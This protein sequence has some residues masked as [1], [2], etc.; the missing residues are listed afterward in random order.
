MSE[1]IFYFYFT[2]I[3]YAKYYA[4]IVESAKTLASQRVW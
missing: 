2:D 3:E 4:K 1:I